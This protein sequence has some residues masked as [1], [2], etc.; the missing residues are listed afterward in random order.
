MNTTTQM[1]T[2]MEARSQGSRRK[3]L[4]KSKTATP[5]AA[6]PAEP[7]P[8]VEPEVPDWVNETPPEFDYDLMVYDQ[9][10]GEL[11]H[12][13]LTRDEYIELKHFLAGLRGIIVPAATAA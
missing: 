7:A 12:I 9:H 3:P 4:N 8:E 2:A 1:R 10:E 13:A 11:Q 6:A 5:P